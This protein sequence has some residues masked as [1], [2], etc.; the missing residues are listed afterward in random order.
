MEPGEVD[1]IIAAW[2]MEVPQLDVAPLAVFSRVSRLARHLERARRA[3][4]ADLELDVWEF[5]VLSALRRAGDPYELSPG[6]LVEQT[7]S[8]SGTMTNRIDRLVARGF[9]ERLP[10]ETDGRGVRVRLTGAG[11]EVAEAAMTG[12]V[13]QE[14][15]MLQG[16]PAGDQQRL[17]TLLQR[18]LEPF[19]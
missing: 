6:A 8:T 18:L 13:A 14:R 7:L 19:E 17:A 2:R 12:L 15:A 5:D 9:V 3:A 10:N 11:H 4:F 16:M 1:R